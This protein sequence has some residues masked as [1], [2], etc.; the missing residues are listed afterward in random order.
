LNAT[1]KL[2]AL[3]AAAVIVVGIM[4]F[5]SFQA[6]RQV[7]EGTGARS[8]AYDLLV[9]ARALLN[10]LTDA[11]TGQRGYAA[12]GDETFLIPYLAVRDRARGQWPKCARS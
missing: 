6:F 9:R 1:R 5:A 7:E 4:V 10:D 8:N 11:E 12:T 2:V 3:F